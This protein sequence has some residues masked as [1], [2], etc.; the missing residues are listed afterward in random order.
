MAAQFNPE[1][2]V[3]CE[4]FDY[5]S[6]ESEGEAVLPSPSEFLQKYIRF[7]EAPQ[8]KAC[9]LPLIH[10]RIHHTGIGQRRSVAQMIDIALGNFP[11]HPAHDF[12][13]TGLGQ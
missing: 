6:A 3:G 5:K 13:G 12:A 1:I 10:Q 4:C 8:R 9:L 2:K 7:N 11:Q